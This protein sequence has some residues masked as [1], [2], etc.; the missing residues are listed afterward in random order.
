LLALQGER[1]LEESSFI[2]FLWFPGPT[3]IFTLQKPKEQRAFI[4]GERLNQS[5]Q[6][7][8]LAMARDS[9]PLVIVHG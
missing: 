9:A 6:N 5:Q 8:V 3:E 2:R 4:P 1:S 7:V